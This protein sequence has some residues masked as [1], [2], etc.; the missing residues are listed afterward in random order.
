MPYV[1]LRPM[2]M[3]LLGA[4]KIERGGYAGNKRA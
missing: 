4:E 2:L 3:S 1:K